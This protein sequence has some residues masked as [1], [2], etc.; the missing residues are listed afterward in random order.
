MKSDVEYPLNRLEVSNY[1]ELVK[2]NGIVTEISTEF[3]NAEFGLIQIISVMELGAEH[4]Q[5]GIQS[6]NDVILYSDQIGSIY[7]GD[8]VEITGFRIPF[9]ARIS[10]SRHFAILTNSIN[11][12]NNGTSKIFSQQDIK[13]FRAFADS[14]NIH[15]KITDLFFK[16]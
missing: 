12:I 3:Y 16:E 2:V 13:K 1:Q 6:S 14:P 10:R 11:K 5:K 4:Q 15:Q 9:Q 8:R 7:L